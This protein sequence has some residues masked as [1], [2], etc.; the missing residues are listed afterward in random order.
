MATRINPFAAFIAFLEQRLQ[1][2]TSVQFLALPT[3]QSH[4]PVTSML[5]DGD[6]IADDDRGRAQKTASLNHERFSELVNQV[7]AVDARVVFSGDFL[8]DIYERVLLHAQLPAREVDDLLLPNATLTFSALRRDFEHAR[9]MS[10]TGDGSIWYPID[11]IPP[12]DMRDDAG[13]T[14][15]S[16][17][18]AHF[19]GLGHEV[20]DAVAS[21]LEPEPFGPGIEA[22]SISVEVFLLRFVRPW[23]HKELLSS[24]AWKW[25]FGEEPLSDGGDPP[26]GLLPAYITGVVFARRCTISIRPE[27]PPEN[28]TPVAR[29]ASG[30]SVG[31]WSLDIDS[32]SRFQPDSLPELTFRE[33]ISRVTSTGQPAPTIT[34]TESNASNLVLDTTGGPPQKLFSLPIVFESTAVRELLAAQLALTTTQ[35]ADLQRQQTALQAGIETLRNAIDNLEQEVRQEEAQIATLSI[36]IEHVESRIETTESQFRPFDRGTERLDQ[37]K[38]EMAAIRKQVESLNSQKTRLVNQRIQHRATLDELTRSRST[39][40]EKLEHSCTSLT[41]VE[42]ALEN[43]KEL[44]SKLRRDLA[45]LEALSVAQRDLDKAFILCTINQITPQSPDPDPALF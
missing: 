23:F 4:W 2:D 6:Q 32:L 14:T 11:T 35:L 43:V 37:W 27:E 19:D 24:R 45:R 39:N 26:A 5:F 1:L 16:L 20:S 29:M 28:P 34:P 31:H 40:Q 25:Q 13:W 9:K 15:I 18:R 10:V 38:R 7:P 12:D 21:W 42:S 3:F 30:A 22:T 44:E 41:A 33:F 36:Q 17:E 8:W